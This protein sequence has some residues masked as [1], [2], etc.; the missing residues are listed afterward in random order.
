MCVGAINT[1]LLSLV[2]S[3]QMKTS[4]YFHILA[5]SISDSEKFV[6]VRCTKQDLWATTPFRSND[7]A[8]KC[9]QRAKRKGKVELKP[10]VWCCSF[11]VQIWP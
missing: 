7:T 5:V 6:S 11:W 1:P 2:P 3:S 4:F 10:K 8:E 9:F